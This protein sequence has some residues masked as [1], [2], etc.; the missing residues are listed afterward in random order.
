MIK[1]DKEK[2][3]YC[4]TCVDVCPSLVIEKKN[5]T[6]VVAHP[7]A[8]INCYHCVGVCPVGAVSCD[9][10]P[11][12]AFRPASGMKSRPTPAAVRNMLTMRRSVREFQDREVP[13]EIL[14]DLVAAATHAPTGINAQTVHLSIITR[15][16]LL[17]REDLR[18]L[19]MVDEL[20]PIVA[21]PIN[22]KL[23]KALGSDKMADTL[24]EQRNTVERIKKASGVKRLNVF[25]GAPVVV[26]A[27]SRGDAPAGKEDCVIAL[28]HMMFQAAAYG[29]GST[30]C[31]FLVTAAKFNP[32]VKKPLG[33]PFNHPIHAAMFLG[34]PKYEYPRMIPRKEV[35]V[36]WID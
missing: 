33:V 13:R 34:W 28:S 31:G 12:E 10:F 24:A 22:I 17:D 36:K 3:K 8:C 20:A 2:C 11:H 32:L 21:S 27:H 5:R 7:G 15:R 6:A 35:P 26:V 1:I 19:K 16:E 9:E 25:R 29:L 30:W 18:I 23:L 4:G 14:E